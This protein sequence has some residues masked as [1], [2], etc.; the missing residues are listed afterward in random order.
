MSEMEGKQTGSW[1]SV[2]ILFHYLQQHRYAKSDLQVGTIFHLL[3]FR[4]IDPERKKHFN[5]MKK[6]YLIKI[7]TY[8]SN[9]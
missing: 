2:T 9:V 6:K 3:I 1:P 8:I 5:E 7:F 4:L